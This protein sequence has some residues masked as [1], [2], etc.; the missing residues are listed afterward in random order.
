MTRE[1]DFYENFYQTNTGGD[2]TKLY[3]LFETQIGN[4]KTTDEIQFH[5]SDPLIKYHQKASNIFCLSSLA[6]AFHSIGNNRA[7]TALVNCIE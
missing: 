3:Q 6:S 2:N 4:A 7:V 1:P 5:P